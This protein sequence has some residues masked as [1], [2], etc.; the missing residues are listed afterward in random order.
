QCRLSRS[1]SGCFGRRVVISPRKRWRRQFMRRN[2]RWG[3]TIAVLGAVTTMS[4]CSVNGGG[5][6][7][8]LFGGGK[9]TLALHGTFDPVSGVS[10]G[11]GEFHDHSNTSKV[12]AHLDAGPFPLSDV[13]TEEF[14]ILTE[15]C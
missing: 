9:V 10:T 5:W 11:S 4:G 15:E 7:I 8:S 6:L 2:L 13:Q 1:S 3:F 12:D 14:A